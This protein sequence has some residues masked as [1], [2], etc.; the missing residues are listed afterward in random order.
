[1]AI[2]EFFAQQPDALHPVIREIIGGAQ[3]WSAADAFAALE[4]AWVARAALEGWLPAKLRGWR[5]LATHRQHLRER[6]AALRA[7]QVVPD[8]E[9]M[10][11]LTARMDTA[12]VPLPAVVR[13]VNA[14]IAAYWRLV[15]RWV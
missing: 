11:V 1:M 6:R 12:V 4:V 2:R 7:E 10:R 15:S 5:W 8:R 14:L 13:P 9:W 3:R